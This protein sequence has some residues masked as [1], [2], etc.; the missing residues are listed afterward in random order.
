MKHFLDISY[1][2]LNKFGE[3]ICGD[4]VKIARTDTKTWAVLSDGLGSGIKASILA[5]LTS[6][7][8]ITML[9]ADAALY[10]V[11]ETILGTLPIC[12]V[13]NIAYATF[14][15]VEI[16]HHS[17]HFR[18]MNFD[19]PETFFF[20]A[21]GVQQKIEPKILNI[22]DKKILLREGTLE[23][24]DFLAAVSDGVWYAGLGQ[25]FNFGWGWNNIAEFMADILHSRVNTAQTVVERVLD[26]TNM[27]YGSQP[28]DDATLVGLYLRPRHSAMMFTGPPLDRTEDERCAQRITEF[29]GRKIVCGGTT[30][31]I[32]ARYLRQDIDVE[33]ATLKPDMPPIGVLDGIDLLT[34]GIL[35]ISKAIEHVKASRGDY[36]RLPTDI[37]GATMLALEILY[38]DDLHFLVGQQINPFYQNP[39]LPVSISIRKNLVEQLARLLRELHKDV[40]IEYC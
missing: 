16:D 2:S 26:Y 19:N 21:G 20:K 17:F 29:D 13:R 14:T 37:N 25:T 27:L 36:S 38:A 23:E 32:V 31:N 4:Q 12:K 3:E 6:Q 1:Q 18:V 40:T 15:V 22:L 8:I 5:T 39:L 7:I 28:G 9:K 33:L 11:V 10:D 34:E 24:G 35:T 30:G